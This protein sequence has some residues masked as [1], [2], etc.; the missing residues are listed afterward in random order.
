M[1]KVVY[2]VYNNQNKLTVDF[3]T[4]Q[5]PL[6]HIMKEKIFVR[7]KLDPLRYSKHT[8]TKSNLC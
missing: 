5:K 2:L 7:N 1:F 8:V 3:A 6:G 4:H